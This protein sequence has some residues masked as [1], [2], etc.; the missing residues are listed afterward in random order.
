M[1][2]VLQRINTFAPSYKNV[3]MP[4]LPG[5]QDARAVVRPLCACAA[6]RTYAPDQARWFSCST[7][8]RAI[9]QVV[10]FAIVIWRNV[11]QQTLRLFMAV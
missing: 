10:D 4:A 2:A 1:A 7:G 11:K 9:V 5:T 8:H 3:T 6:R